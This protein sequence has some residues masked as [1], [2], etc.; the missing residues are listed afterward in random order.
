M[1]Y[2]DLIDD[3]SGTGKVL[4]RRHPDSFFLSSAEIAFIA[5]HQLRHP[6]RTRLTPTHRF[7]SKFVTVV[8]SGDT[9][10]QIHLS[11]FQVSN[12]AMGMIR[13]H[14]IDASMSATQMRVRRSTRDQY[15]P[16]VFYKYKNEYGTLVQGKADPMFP[17]EY[18][19]VTLT[20]GFPQRPEP[21][22][23]SVE[24]PIENRG[25]LAHQDMETVK[26][27]LM[28]PDSSSIIWEAVSD[29]H[30]LIYLKFSGLFSEVWKRLSFLL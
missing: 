30:M 23:R 4:C 22:F 18:L 10:Q 12:T 1:I 6:N 7:G 20:E 2:T 27:K 13:D 24:F 19:L 25:G 5:Q 28:R 17:V 11:A 26:A 3:G 21:L 16:D 15:V 9:E 14:V 29:F 8:V